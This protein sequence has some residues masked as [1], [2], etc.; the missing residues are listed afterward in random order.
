V[1]HRRGIARAACGA[2]L[3]GAVAMSCAR[4][5]PL[6]D[7]EVPTVS[8]DTAPWVVN[9]VGT[10]EESSPG[11]GVF[12][13]QPGEYRARLPADFRRS[14]VRVVFSGRPQPLP[15]GRRIVGRPFVLFA[16]RRERSAW[17][18]FIATLREHLAPMRGGDASER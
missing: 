9:A 8:V 15:S 5:A 14:G 2:M 7:P 6:D 13:L 18:S 16:I 10:I 3:V 1:T 4:E 12:L 11:S 17:D